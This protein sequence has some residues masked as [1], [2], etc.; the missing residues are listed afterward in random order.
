MRGSEKSWGGLDA[1]LAEL[2]KAVF[3]GLAFCATSVCMPSVSPFVRRILRAP[4]KV[5]A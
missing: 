1:R 2:L 4:V 5:K 3:V